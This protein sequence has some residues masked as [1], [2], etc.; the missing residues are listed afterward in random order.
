MTRSS[1][2]RQTILVRTLLLIGGSALLLAGAFVLLWIM[3]MLDRVAEIEFDR[4]AER[5]EARIE[6]TF[7]PVEQLLS[8]GADMVQAQPP[9]IEHPESFNALF[10]AVIAASPT[11]TSVVGGMPDGRNWLLQ[12][13]PGGHWRNRLGDPARWGD[14]QHFIDYLP[15]GSQRTFSEHFRFD[16]RRRPWYVG[17]MGEA[18]P[19]TAHWTPPYYFLSSDH[20][21]ITASRRVTLADGNDFV[22]GF[23]VTLRDL[24]L[25]TLNMQI[26]ENGFALILTEDERV[27][28][29]P[30]L[31]SGVSTADWTG[32]LLLPATALGIPAVN[33]AL[34]LWRQSR[35]SA[36]PV[37]R[38]LSAGVP[39]LASVRGYQLGEHRLWVFTLA[40]AED[41]APPWPMIGTTLGVLLVLLLVVAGLIT[42]G[43]ARRIARPLEDLAET[44]QRI[45]QLDFSP[46]AKVN[47][48]IAEIAQLAQAQDGM[49]EMLRVSQQS[50]RDQAARLLSQVTELREAEERINAL[51]FYDPLTGLPNRRLLGDRLRRALGSC[52]RHHQH[53]AVL[54][55]DLDNFKAL[56]DTQG[57]ALG[58]A[59]LKEVAQRLLG[60]VRDTDTVARLGGDEFVIVLEELDGEIATATAQTRAIAGKVLEALGQPF[61]LQGEQHTTSGSIGAT[62]FDGSAGEIEEF[63]KQADLAMYQAKAEGRSRLCFYGQAM[64]DRLTARTQ[65]ETELRAAI[66]GRQ[67][68]LHYQPQVDRQ[69]R[70]V[71]AEALLRWQHP[72]LGLLSPGEVVPVAEETG[73]ILPIGHQVIEMACRQLAR[74]AQQPEMAALTVSVNV[75]ARQFRHAGFVGDVK[76]SLREAGAN[77]ALLRIELTES[78]L[79]EDVDQ[80]IARM[81]ELRELGVSFSLDDFGTGYSSL[82]YLKRLPLS[83]LK[84]DRSFV[85]DVLVD[86]NDAAISETVIALAHTMGLLVTAEGVEDEAQ[87]SLLARAGCD[88]YQGYLI[89]RPAPAE[90]LV[91]P[92]A[93]ALVA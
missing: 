39:W 26:G 89:G 5:V 47:T 6:R 56:N 90:E 64:H 70:M 60:C 78:M 77:P 29:L 91:V 81:M 3:P 43:Q 79:L 36:V 22:L 11:I 16:P 58:D 67:F 82:A 23:D 55:L 53:G 10:K 34:S 35:R 75:S 61:A 24:S 68:I 1:T 38:L 21:G 63:F 71:G 65:L 31:P 93:P 46:T 15:D 83:E 14:Q 27:L 28:A 8:A 51:A 30:A 73:L 85:R 84:I 32:S 66:A 72:R 9:H 42:L 45:G 2:L 25:A 87:R 54:F 88:T 52:K 12:E 7:A 40:P 80:V 4:M 59:L 62:L 74:W 48:R 18:E 37:T 69:G 76:A 20:P 86:P 50:L 33:D 92:P 49:R 13:S 19:G 44:S 41:F 17:A 57:H